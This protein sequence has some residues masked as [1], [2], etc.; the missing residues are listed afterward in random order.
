VWRRNPS[1]RIFI[2]KRPCRYDDEEGEGCA[3]EANVE[4]V[5]DVLSEVAGYKSKD[6]S[7]MLAMML[8]RCEKLER[9]HRQQRGGR[10]I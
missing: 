1:L 9:V 7:A 8:S 3:C 5:V 10:C 2:V 4:G 6:L